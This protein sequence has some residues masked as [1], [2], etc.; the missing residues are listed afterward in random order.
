MEW[1]PGEM[2]VQELSSN[3]TK[4]GLT[5]KVFKYNWLMEYN[6][7]FLIVQHLFVILS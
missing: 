5:D 7:T 4:K 1:S 2:C 3:K 6:Y